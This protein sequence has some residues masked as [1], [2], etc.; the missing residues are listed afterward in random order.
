MEM[1]S[2][3]ASLLCA[4]E[5]GFFGGGVDPVLGARC[6]C[7]S[8]ERLCYSYLTLAHEYGCVYACLNCPVPQSVAY[9]LLSSASGL[10]LLPVPS[11]C[12]AK[13]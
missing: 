4:E 11:L 6:C 3:T 13:V 1:D 12:R 5:R 2:R 10:S 9:G 8:A 7:K